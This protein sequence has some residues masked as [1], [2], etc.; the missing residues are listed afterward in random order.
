MTE[1]QQ[2]RWGALRSFSPTVHVA[3]DFVKKVE[4]E[5]VEKVSPRMAGS[6]DQR[7]ATAD[8]R[9]MVENE[10]CADGVNRRGE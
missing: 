5:K 2:Y 6:E 9:H 1:K 4:V 8:R 3:S 7:W 10:K